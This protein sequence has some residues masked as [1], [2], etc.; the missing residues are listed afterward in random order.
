VAVGY[1][2]WL[3]AAASLGVLAGG[4]LGWLSYE[5]PG[6]LEQDKKLS[7]VSVTLAIE[8]TLNGKEKTHE[9]R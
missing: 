7:F 8:I 5:D 2:F 1:Q 6:G 9:G 4:D 3:P